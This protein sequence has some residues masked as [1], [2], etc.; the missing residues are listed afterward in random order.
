LFSIN[1][2]FQPNKLQSEKKIIKQPKTLILFISS[3]EKKK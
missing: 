2:V 1:F 3:K